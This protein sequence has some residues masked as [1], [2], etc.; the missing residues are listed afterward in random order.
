MKYFILASGSTGNCTFVDFGGTRIL[1]DCGI[2]KRQLITKLHQYHYDICD[3]DYVFLTH[4]HSDHNKNIHLFHEDLIYCGK[5]TIP[6]LRMDHFVNPYDILTFNDITVIPL[7]ISHDATSPLG[8][9]FL[10]ENIKFV[11]MTDTGYVSKKN[12]S[13]MVD[14]GYYVM[15]SN[16]D[17]E[18]LMNTSRP[19]YLKNRIISDYGHLSNLDS[20]MIMSH[21]LGPSTKEI[22]LAH[23]SKEANTVEKALT[24][25]KEVFTQRKIELSSFQIKVASPIDVV[26]GGEIN[27]QD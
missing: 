15:E 11:Y 16:H 5:G 23:L 25:Y 21:L 6:S 8:F 3:I 13:Y 27:D 9:V 2:S 18:M 10:K 22:V 20:A 12:A 7:S 19:M 24:T 4:D 17:I 26:C 1:I 14:A